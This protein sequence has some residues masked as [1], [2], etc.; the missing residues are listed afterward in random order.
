M[1]CFKLRFCTLKSAWPVGVI[2]VSRQAFSGFY[3]RLRVTGYITGVSIDVYERQLKQ[4][5]RIIFRGS[6]QT[7]LSESL[8]QG[9]FIVVHTNGGSTAMAAQ[10]MQDSFGKHTQQLPNDFS[11]LSVELYK[12]GQSVSTPS[13]RIKSYVLGVAG[14]F[15]ICAAIIILLTRQPPLSHRSFGS[16]PPIK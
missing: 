16:P 4:L 11:Q 1:V 3:K 10:L 8:L 2:G 15:T 6:L 13:I 7:V 12:Y 5:L 14:N 9:L